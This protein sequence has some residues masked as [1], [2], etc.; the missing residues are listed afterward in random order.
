MNAPPAVSVLVL[1]YNEA[2]YLPQCIDSILMQETSFPFEI[3]IHDDAS[4]DGSQHILTE[5]A[6]VHRL[7]ERADHIHIRLFFEE[8]NQYSQ[9]VNIVQDILL[10]QAQGEFI[11]YLEADDYWCR[12]DKLALQYVY[13]AAHPECSMCVHATRQQYAGPSPFRHPRIFRR[14]LRE[15]NRF[16]MWQT[17]HTMT[18]EDIFLHWYCHT[19]SYFVRRKDAYLPTWARECWC[20][21]YV[22]LTMLST[23]GN[24]TYL[25]QVLSV[26]RTYLPKGITSSGI[27]RG[28][29]NGELPENKD[30][31]SGVLNREMEAQVKKHSREWQRIEYL[32]Q[33]NAAHGGEY[34]DIVIARICQDRQMFEEYMEYL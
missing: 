3:L 21:D 12:Q 24:I 14:A 34:T 18:R 29:A 9:G 10:P 6:R 17:V 33:F 26:Y 5:I 15:R 13:L 1:S 31:S 28:E 22:F 32:R 30:Q 25:P 27:I 8:Q 11:A 19:S 2:E 23:K 7:T 20:G 16:E 4:T